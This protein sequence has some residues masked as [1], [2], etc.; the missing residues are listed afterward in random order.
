MHTNDQTAQLNTAQ[1]LYD[2]GDFSAARQAYQQILE[3]QRRDLPPIDP[4]LAVTLYWLGA[5]L[6]QLSP[7]RP[8]R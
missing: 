6:L 3:L 4:A 1:R 8:R 2:H 7:A 5:T